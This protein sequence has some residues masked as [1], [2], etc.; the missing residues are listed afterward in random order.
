MDRSLY[1]GSA[2]TFRDWKQNVHPLKPPFIAVVVADAAGVPTAEVQGFAQE[3]LK[4]GV[5]YVCAWGR[6]CERVHDVFD[7]VILQRPEGDP[8]VMTTWHDDESMDEA[9][10]YGVWA[11]CPDEAFGDPASASVLFAVIDGGTARMAAVREW[12]KQ[13][14]R[15][16]T[17]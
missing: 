10:W 5:A 12:V 4:Q 7:D 17:E 9:L 16:R 13:G 15:R 6:E 8:F 2:P 14:A 1:L 3:L 11:A